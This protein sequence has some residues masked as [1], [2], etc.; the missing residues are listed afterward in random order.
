MGFALLV[1]GALYIIKGGFAGHKN[2]DD[3]DE[4]NLKG[5]KGLGSNWALGGIM[6]AGGAYAAFMKFFN[7]VFSWIF[8]TWT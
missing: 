5:W 7:S 3:N 2:K 1:A 4:M 6:F 8:A